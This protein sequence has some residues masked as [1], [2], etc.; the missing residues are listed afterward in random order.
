LTL[1]TSHHFSSV[2]TSNTSIIVLLEHFL[3]AL[4]PSIY[5]LLPQYPVL[6]I[7]NVLVLISSL[8]ISNLL[9]V[10]ICDFC[11]RLFIIISS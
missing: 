9:K 7:H 2:T 10:T 5:H 3:W 6:I 8:F 1:T 4:L 11:F